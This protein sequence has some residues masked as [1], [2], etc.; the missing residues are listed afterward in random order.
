MIAALV[1]KILPASHGG[2]QIDPDYIYIAG[3]PSASALAA[4]K[5]TGMTLEKTE[6]K[7]SSEG[8]KSAICTAY[9]DVSSKPHAEHWRISEGGH[10]WFGGAAVGSYTGPQAPFASKAMLTFFLQHSQKA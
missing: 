3:Q 8:D 2:L 9:H 5:K 4:L 1:K 6:S 10:A 7:I